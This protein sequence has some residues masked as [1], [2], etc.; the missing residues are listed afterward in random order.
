MVKVVSEEVMMKGESFELHSLVDAA[1]V[2]GAL[3]SFKGSKPY[4]AAV[5]YY[6]SA[7]LQE[8]SSDMFVVI[9]LLKETLQNMGGNHP[10]PAFNSLVEKIDD[11][12]RRLQ[13]TVMMVSKDVPNHM[14]FV[15]VGGAAFGANQRDYFNIWKA[16]APKGFTFSIWYDPEALMA[17]D[18]SRT[19]IQ[20]AKADAMLAVGD[21]PLANTQLI[22]AYESRL[23]A[24]RRQAAGFIEQAQLRGLSPDAARIE[25]L[26]EA[27]GQN[28][29]QLE[30]ARA[31]YLQS[32]L[33][34]AA[35]NV[36]L[37]DARQAF[38]SHFLWSA[39]NREI[40]LRGNFAAASDIVRLQVEAR[41][42]GVYS[43]LDYL[44]P[45]VQEMAGVNVAGFDEK[46]RTGVLQLLLNHNET[47]MP[48]R[49]AN[50]YADFLKYIPQEHIAALE[51][52]AKSKPLL[53]Q[54]FA[55]VTAQ[56]T[57][58]DIFGMGS[59]F[60]DKGNIP[61]LMNAYIAAHPQ[62]GMTLTTMNLIRYY[63]DTIE[64]V[65]RE[66][67]QKGKAWG[68]E[69]TFNI[70]V[71][72]LG[73]TDSP[74]FASKV[75]ESVWASYSQSVVTGMLHYHR[76]GV[77]PGAQGTIALTG[78]GALLAGSDIYTTLQYTAAGIAEAKTH[79]YLK[80]GYNPATEEDSISGWTERDDPN[81]DWAMREQQAWREGKFK[82]R[83][84]G[85]LGELIK[86][87]NT[88]TFKRGWPVVEGKPVLVTAIVQRLIDDLGEP[89]VRAMTDKLSGEVIFQKSANLSFDERRQILDQAIS[90]LP[91][92]V[93]AQQTGSFN[94]LLVHLARGTLPIDQLSPLQRVVI[95]GLFGAESLD[96]SGFASAWQS[97]QHLAR[98]TAEGGV[99]ARFSAIETLLQQRQAPAFNAALAS[100]AVV[101]EHNVRELKALALTDLMTLSQWGQ[102]IAQIHSTAQWEYRTRILK[103][104]G[105]VREQ[106]FQAG[107]DSARQIPQALLTRTAGDPG[108]RCYPLSL[109]MAAALAAGES[110][111]RALIGRV[112]N[113]SLTPQAADSRALL[114]ALDELSAVRMT[115][116]GKALGTQTLQTVMQTLDANTASSVLLLDTGSHALLAAKVVT[117]DR[118]AYRFFEPNFAVYGFSQSTRLQ[119]AVEGYLRGEGGELA[120]LYGL[121]DTSELRFN[122]IELDTQA[123]AARVLPSSVQVGSLLTN[124]PIP[125]AQ[126]VSVWEQQSALRHRSL[127]E[128]SRM[129]ESLAQLDAYQRVREFDL[130]TTQLR[131]EHS[132][133]REFLPLLDTLKNSGGDQF[134]LTMMDALNPK[135][136]VH[137]TT[138]D[139]RFM[140][141][142][143]HIQHLVES[144]AG[145]NTS[146]G[147]S[148][149]GSRLSFA[150]AIQTLVTEMRSREYQSEHGAVPAL[151]VA[152]QIQVYVSYAQLAFGVVTDAAQ[153]INLVRQ[154]A[155]S[156]QAL[157]KQQ[158]SVSG[159][160]LGRVGAPAGVG[161]SLVNIGFDIHG[162]IV[163]TNQEQRS[164]LTTQLVFDV[165]AL[166]LDVTALAV[167][168]TV[169]AAASAL[170]VPLLGIGIGVTAIAS[171]LGEIN[172][173]A[174]AVGRHLFLIHEAYGPKGCEIKDGVLSFAGEAIIT[175]LD[176]KAR[177]ADFDSQ[178]FFPPIFATVGLPN[179]SKKADDLHRAI[180]I[181]EAMKRDD[182]L[183]F[184]HAGDQGIHTVVLPCTPLC[185]YGYEFQLGS[186]GFA[187]DEDIYS[188]L[189]DHQAHYESLPRGEFEVGMSTSYPNVL[190]IWKEQ[191]EFP[192]SA[193]GEQRFQFFS[194][195]P[196]PHI[197]YKLVPV[198]KPTTISVQLNEHARY[199]VVPELPKEWHQLLSY[200]IS[201]DKG[202]SQL[203][204][205]RGLVS[206]R[207]R[208]SLPVGTESPEGWKD[209]VS[210]LIRAPW[211]S[212]TEI[213][214]IGDQLIVDGIRITG[215]SGFLQLKGGE[216]FQFNPERNAWMLVSITPE[217]PAQV[218]SPVL[219]RLR[220]LSQAKRNATAYIPLHNFVIPFDEGADPQHTTGYYDVAADRMVYVR[221]LP[222]SLME[223]VVLAA[224]A[225][226]Q[227]WFYQ[228]DHATVWRVDAVTGY[229]RHA[230]RLLTPRQ[231]SKIVAAEL[232]ADGKLRVVQETISEEQTR[233]TLEYLI[234][235]NSL[236]FV[237]FN[238]FEKVWREDMF[239]LDYWKEPLSRFRQP[240]TNIDDTT[241][242]DVPLSR[243]QS[244]DFV[245]LRGYNQGDT[246]VS[247]WIRMS[248]FKFYFN[249]ESSEDSPGQ[250]V[251]LMSNQLDDGMIFYDVT[252]R[253]LIRGFP[254]PQKGDF[255][256]DEVLEHDVA[257]VSQSAGRYI[258][259]KTN[260][261]MFDI[262]QDGALVFIGVGK[263]WLE[264]QPDWPNAL[265]ELVTAYGKR[266]FP[267]IG[268]SDF[269]QR[270][271]LAV[272]C[273]DNR[274]LVSQV[275][276]GK[277]LAL[278]G[279]TPDGEA[280]WLLDIEAGQL[281][282]QALS[283][284]SSVREAFAG[285]TKLRNPQHLPIAQKV[286]SDWS[287]AKVEING[288]GLLGR[289]RDGVNLELSDHQPAKIVGVENQWSQT[290]QTGMS[291][292]AR[293]R[294]LLTG[295]DHAPMLTIENLGNSFTYY[296]AEQ[297]YLFTVDARQDG[298]W[299]VLLGVQNQTESLLF[300]PVDSLV[301][302]RG[303]K[304][305][306]WLT[307][308]HA[309]REGEILTL[310]TEY[311]IDDL[312][313]L[314]VDGVD[315]LI[316]AFGG[317]SQICRVAE[318]VWQRLECL[319]VDRRN[320]PEQ[321]G[322][323]EHNL[324]LEMA[325]HDQMLLSEAGGNLLLIDPDSA[326]TLM[327]LNGEP[328]EA[329]GRVPLYLSFNIQGREHKYS[330]GQL[331]GALKAQKH[332][333]VELKTVINSLID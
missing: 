217:K 115:D 262:A 99:F 57:P 151:S 82:A 242:M 73:E 147:E 289:T 145:K 92:S 317:M 34:L 183:E 14:H 165:A 260:G 326:R 270:A 275:S 316:L 58:A 49:D 39:Y 95:G 239:G 236:T 210:W 74:F 267:V 104:A 81:G 193:N 138:A 60:D 265:P 294:K 122:V 149:G 38:K 245:A 53:H 105:G 89:F 69:E 273:I 157:V 48:G 175:R 274:L 152:L 272:W 255:L 30:V 119:H 31:R 205:T 328:Q 318:E 52:F 78:P 118:T 11:Y 323:F 101:S 16:Q 141:I 284:A 100:K 308:S 125:G 83:Y 228:P 184:G 254:E 211:V 314:L 224:V 177:R 150:F 169:G 280:G 252:N 230:Y 198:N 26:V 47:L 263:R 319:V 174:R 283:S 154:V 250:K 298:Q 332:N 32:H 235:E 241:A 148:D 285:G 20:A 168:G 278:L 54:I 8:K 202:L 86:P 216:L 140:R 120:R 312:Q 134:T 166:A 135:N 195:S 12:H 301:L 163:A 246:V 251:L 295:H 22:K 304:N 18:V 114:V 41:E 307:D 44:P 24:L 111:E 320:T 7:L 143:R 189:R 93:G 223:G 37:Q 137:V 303:S 191:I 279:L 281:Y 256:P 59:P 25:F 61:S 288:Q 266:P 233:Y 33:E 106:F 40:S 286:W 27:F 172:D 121:A 63:Y 109:L 91:E 5:S 170:S 249:Y 325:G 247:G 192:Y 208:Q 68:D 214:F 212:D 13:N 90:D 64:V 297:D 46:A 10:S 176:L 282:R 199:L 6:E 1:E 65:E 23:V 9:S 110:A 79:R 253:S 96:V 291:L 329:Q 185:Y 271:M 290:E 300:D 94:E 160:L 85:N 133:G 231:G 2:K 258:M 117:G 142:K 292:N 277:E 261:R 161:F 45:L 123:I 188:R 17:F 173:K 80:H 264:Q 155:A 66:L 232:M 187:P 248:D 15:W 206:V 88:L 203:T 158:A 234:A 162:L 220:A 171:N 71:R 116:V 139:S 4:M 324:V 222:A 287:F 327:I 178:K 209:T 130:A 243:W 194:T 153:V 179:Y 200:D 180:N 218:S 84:T 97:A 226:S 42:G 313:P 21:N 276:P 196:F 103:R 19:L 221:D 156:E 225:G 126:S 146:P 35:D 159:R 310:A 62:A 124:Q 268:V 127:S 229:V 77:I 113:A 237:H 67:D 227:A 72:K 28:K 29:A 51:A 219:Q 167:G 98:E 108:R 112:A 107:A 296:V 269:T 204:L 322:S 333:G 181:R 76:D 132:L 311:K 197:L 164:R 144:A 331:H 201:A 238:A 3:V 315:T 56:A 321:I 50:R 131:S 102:H 213:G 70:I 129:G 244:A 36:Q 186:A 257:E 190:D 207:L 43:D 128:N 299:S 87:G 259:T 55:P 240:D 136:S 330:L 215:F 182:H 305:Q 293:L 306:I 75:L 302:N 309:T